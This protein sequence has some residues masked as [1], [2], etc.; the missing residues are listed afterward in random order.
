M[1]VAIP[2]KDGRPLPAVRTGWELQKRAVRVTKLPFDRCELLAIALQFFLAA[3]VQ[4][5]LDHNHVGVVIPTA[6]NDDVGYHQC[7]FR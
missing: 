1:P 3:V 6:M 5:D 2:F 4:F 7:I